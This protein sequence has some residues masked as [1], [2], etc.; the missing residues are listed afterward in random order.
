[1]V[2]IVDDEALIAA[3]VVDLVS[4]H[5]KAAGYQVTP[6][7]DGV[8]AMAAARRELPALLVLDL[9]LPE[10]S[11][12]EV[13][14]TLRSHETTARIP[15]VML[16]ARVEE[17]DRVLGFE[18]GADDYVTKPFSPRELVLRI[19]AVLRR[20]GEAAAEGASQV[21]QVGEIVLDRR[22]YTVH[23][24]GQ[25]V[26]LTSTEFKLLAMLMERIGRVQS[27]DALLND[28]WA[29]ETAI[30]SRTVDTHMRRLREK[31]GEAAK[32]IQT[33][34]GFGYRISRAV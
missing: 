28:V 24:K 23:V 10:M 15:I 16:T 14:K 5:L 11:G 25:A 34:R 31:L 7:H 8:Q 19:Q 13:C 17:I 26:D 18:L 27:R 21:L 32:C 6:A 12:L 22:R 29:R 20:I 33:V 1:M 9:M 2:Y 4:R 30:D 3:D